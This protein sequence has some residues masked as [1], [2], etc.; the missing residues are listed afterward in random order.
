MSN[1]ALLILRHD[2]PAAH[3]VRSAAD[4]VALA[5]TSHNHDRTNIV[6]DLMVSI[7]ERIIDN[8]LC[9]QARWG[10]NHIRDR[11]ITYIKENLHRSELTVPEIANYLNVSRATLYRA[12]ENV[13]GLKDFIV[14]ERIYAAQS[15]LRTGRIDRGFITSVAY[16]TGFS[17]PEQFSKVFKARTGVSPTR[18]VRDGL[19]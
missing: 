7:S 15:K 5:L 2:E 1:E 3:L 13:G 4:A 8:A 11:A 16:N 12:F 19:S 17:S 14:S 10:H 9:D 6:R 18:F